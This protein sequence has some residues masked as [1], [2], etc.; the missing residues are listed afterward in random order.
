MRFP[1]WMSWPSR[2]V[3]NLLARPRGSVGSSPP[4]GLLPPHA[5]SGTGRALPSQSRAAGGGR[6]LCDGLAP[7]RLAARR[8]AIPG[9]AKRVAA[10]RTVTPG[11]RS[12]GCSSGGS[13]RTTHRPAGAS[14]ASGTDPTRHTGPKCG[15]PWS[16]VR[17]ALK[18]SRAQSDWEAPPC[19]PT[20]QARGRRT[21]HPSRPRA[22]RTRPRAL[23]GPSA[24]TPRPP[25][26]G[27]AR[28]V[29]PPR[30]PPRGESRRPQCTR[31]VAPGR[32]V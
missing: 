32:G 20:R 30:C 22:P 15:L 23:R 7:Q 28:R 8:C 1:G 18:S 16:R 26:P 12:A 9:L 4:G 24:T 31:R 21:G 14:G 6:S 11:L 5:V 17:A 2:S 29:S 10:C 19:G 25:H 13:Q 3:G 27:G